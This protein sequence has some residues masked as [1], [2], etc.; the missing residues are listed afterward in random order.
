MHL[1]LKSSTIESTQVYYN[2]APIGSGLVIY[3]DVDLNADPSQI[4]FNYKT[5]GWDIS[6]RPY[7]LVLKIYEF[8]NQLLL[9]SNL[10]AGAILSSSSTVFYFSIFN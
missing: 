2:K 7:Y 10:T 5:Y 3:E 9:D 4:D 1:D 8:S 6:T